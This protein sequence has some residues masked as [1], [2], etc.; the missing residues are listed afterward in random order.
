MDGEIA[1]VI[2]YNNLINNAQRIIIANYLSSKY[3]IPI[4]LTAEKYSFDAS[5][6]NDVA[7]I[8]RV[9]PGKPTQ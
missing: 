9:N 7:G 2:I 5:Y 1:E 8:G 6:G 3:D 4:P